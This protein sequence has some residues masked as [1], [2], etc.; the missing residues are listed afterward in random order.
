MKL[1][2][3]KLIGILGSDLEI[4]ADVYAPVIHAQVYQRARE[5][6]DSILDFIN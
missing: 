1:T 4:Y 2:V 3:N 5:I 6:I